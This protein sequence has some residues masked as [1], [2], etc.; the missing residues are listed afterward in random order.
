MSFS[1]VASR[2]SAGLFNF[3]QQRRQDTPVLPSTST[4][5]GATVVTGFQR[6]TAKL[7]AGI[8]TSTTRRGTL[9]HARQVKTDLSTLA[10]GLLPGVDAATETPLAAA[11]PAASPTTSDVPSDLDALLRAMQPGDAADA[12]V[13]APTA[14]V[15]PTI[16]SDLDTLLS[17]VQ[18][19][20]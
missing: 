10:S 5:E 9:P 13:Q 8:S 17:A 2:S 4:S 16:A 7:D 20:R 6:D 15:R 14:M 18:S 1:V 12:P 3:L 19:G 11:D